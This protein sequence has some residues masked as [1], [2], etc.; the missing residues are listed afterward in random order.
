MS[1]A[2]AQIA[3][4]LV[5]GLREVKGRYA[6][7]P[8]QWSQIFSKGKSLLQT[9]KT[10]HTR[11]LG[12]PSLKNQGQSVQFDNNAGTRFTYNHVHQVIGLGYSITEEAVDDNLY[13]QQ[14]DPS[15][16]ELAESFL[17]FKEILAANVFNNGNVY[18]PAVGGDGLSLFN[19][20]HLV[21]GNTVANTPLVQMGLNEASLDMGT[22]MVRRFRNYANLLIGAQ[23]ERLL[24]PVELRRVADR[25]YNTD[26]RPGTADN[27]KNSVKEGGD[28]G[29][30]YIVNDFLTSPYAWF[31]LTNK[32]GFICLQRKEFDISM[33]VDF[34]TNNLMVKAT[35]R[36]YIGYDDWRAGWGSFPTN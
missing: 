1:L 36:Y 3:P 8:A 20:G 24:V 25:L 19:T 35:E 18:N 17:Q 15:N 7:I 16:L 28:L 22:N 32:P 6:M 13:K 14:F 29:K 26:R 10:V 2:T 33:Q 4:L 11:M 30:G 21:D 31:L 27:D 5:P 23:V 12:L 9:E 34:T